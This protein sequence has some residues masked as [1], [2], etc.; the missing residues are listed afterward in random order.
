MESIYSRSRLRELRIHPMRLSMV[1]RGIAPHAQHR[2]DWNTDTLLLP[3]QM[4]IL[5]T[6]FTARDLVV[7]QCGA[8]YSPAVSRGLHCPARGG[9]PCHQRRARHEGS[10]EPSSSRG[11]REQR[12]G[13][14]HRFPGRSR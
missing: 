6:D 13:A 2:R 7:N 8:P 14:E 1:L 9:D 11:L 12:Q 5:F 3:G 10:R 4:S